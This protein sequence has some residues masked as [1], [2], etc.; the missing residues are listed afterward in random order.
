MKNDKIIEDFWFENYFNNGLCGLCGNT[1]RID[2][3]ESAISPQ[4]I[5]AG[6]I[7]YCLCPNGRALKESHFTLKVSTTPKS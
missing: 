3:S 6:G 5:K 4:G 7:F 1:G 2:T